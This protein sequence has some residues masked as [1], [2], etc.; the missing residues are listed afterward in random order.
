MDKYWTIA[1]IELIDDD[2][3]E[4]TVYILNDFIK[5]TYVYERSEIASGLIPFVSI[6][7]SCM[8]RVRLS[9][10]IAAVDSELS[11][12]INGCKDFTT[13]IKGDESIKDS[14]VSGYLARNEGYN[15]LLKRAVLA[16][17]KREL[18]KY[19][20]DSTERQMFMF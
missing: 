6:D 17:T 16:E 8:E 14:S 10:E 2:D 3:V 13:A 12:A 1:D 20:Y 7:D 11:K 5:T 18:L 9:D 19:R 4:V 15:L